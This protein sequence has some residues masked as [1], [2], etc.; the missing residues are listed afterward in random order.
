MCGNFVV[1]TSSGTSSLH[2]VC[3]RLPRLS[4][5]KR[6]K[7]RAAPGLRKSCSRL[8]KDLLQDCGRI[9]GG[10]DLDLRKSYF[11]IAAKLPIQVK[12]NEEEKL[13][14]DYEKKIL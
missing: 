7:T 4:S 5:S 6:G 12:D 2:F 10:V 8:A 9:A 1:R 11:K 13:L 14:K 3:F